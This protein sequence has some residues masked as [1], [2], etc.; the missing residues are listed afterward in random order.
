MMLWRM[1]GGLPHAHW[2]VSAIE[3]TSGQSMVTPRARGGI[4]C[5]IKVHGLS[6]GCPTCTGKVSFELLCCR[7][8]FVVAPRA[9]G[10]I[11][12]LTSNLD[13]RN[14]CPTA[15]GEVSVTS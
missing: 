5:H 6:G 14:G 9:R 4:Q 7:H 3:H 8:Y 15:H 10:C 13:F 12:D 11:V 2:D 1:L